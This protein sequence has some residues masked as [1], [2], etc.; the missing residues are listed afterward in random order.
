M[1]MKVK[2][3][4]KSYAYLP[5]TV[6][7]RVLT[8]DPLPEKVL[9]LVCLDKDGREECTIVGDKQFFL[10]LGETLRENADILDNFNGRPA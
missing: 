1:K 8:I 7:L 10:E 5:Y 3:R 2:S 4:Y 9:G 6:E